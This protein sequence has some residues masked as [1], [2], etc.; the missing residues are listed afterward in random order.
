MAE[1]EWAL[2]RSPL[3]I[4]IFSLCTMGGLVGGSW[5]YHQQMQLEQKKAQQALKKIEEKHKKSQAALEVYQSFAD[6]FKDLQK[7]NFL[8][9]TE[10]SNQWVERIEGLKNWQNFF[11]IIRPQPEGKQSYIISGVEMEK[12]FKVYLWRLRLQIEILH[13]GN[14]LEFIDHLYSSYEDGLYNLQTCQFGFKQ[15]FDFKWQDNIQGVG[16]EGSCL[17]QWYAG[18]IQ[19]EENEEK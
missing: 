14:F 19:S 13:M 3:I 1:I 2:L 4:L 18:E 16:L 7:Y 17:L 8:Q 9:P 10:R 11:T 6:K 15:N 5:Y 12:D